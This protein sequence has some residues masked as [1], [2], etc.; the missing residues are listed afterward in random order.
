MKNET[1]FGKRLIIII[2]INLIIGLYILY[3]TLTVKPIQEQC[4]QFY[5]EKFEQYNKQMSEENKFNKIEYTDKDNK[6]I[7]KMLLQLIYMMIQTMHVGSYLPQKKIDY[8]NETAEIAIKYIIPMIKQEQ[9]QGHDLIQFNAKNILDNKNS[10]NDKNKEIIKLQDN[11]Q[12]FYN[13]QYLS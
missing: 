8:Y 5:N 10:N 1:K 4:L 12:N 13:Y 6:T 9:P 11:Y 7:H 3:K 2:I